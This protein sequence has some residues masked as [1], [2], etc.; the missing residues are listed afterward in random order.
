MNNRTY[1]LATVLLIL[2]ALTP[3][4]AE[5]TGAP[6]TT[7]A[8]SGF[9]LKSDFLADYGYSSDGGG[10]A[11]MMTNALSQS[12]QFIVLERTAISDVFA[13]QELTAAGLVRAESAAAPGQLIGA[14]ILVVGHVTE[15]SEAEAGDSMS[16]GLAD[17]GSKSLGI[18]L[19]PSS[20]EGVVGIDV[21]LIDATTGQIVSTFSVRA[22]KKS[23]SLGLRV[24]AKDLDFGQS[25]F[26][27]SALGKAARK[28]INKATKQIVDAAVAV[29]WQGRIVDVDMGEVIINAGDSAGVAIGDR[30]Q[31]YRVS[32][33]L[34][35]P[36]TGRVLG[37]RKRRVAEIQIFET[38]QE[39]AFGRVTDGEH[40]E[41]RSN[42][43]VTL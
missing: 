30:Y 23:S 4:S 10:L 2:L 25:S 13:E 5:P 1:S 16:L 33:V 34:R 29:E 24:S 28:A 32:K 6:K 39:M 8:I 38:H 20:V 37:Q 22:K 21:R 27:D 43:I 19:A 15:F 35:D 18:G 7:I 41:L 36:Q 14:Q 26:Q 31:V 11:A 9:D 3:A 40:S 17:L 42:D 12:G